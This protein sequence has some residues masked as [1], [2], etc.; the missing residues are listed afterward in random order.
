[1]D[2]Y[3]R[4]KILCA[5]KGYRPQSAEILETLGVSSGTITGWRKGSIPDFKTLQKIADYFGVTVGYLMGISDSPH[6]EDVVE[7]I[8]D[9]LLDCGA[10]VFSGA[11]DNGPERTVIY[12]RNVRIFNDH[13]YSQICSDISA[14][15][16]DAEI[17]IA[18]AWLKKNVGQ[19]ETPADESYTDDEKDLIRK[20]RQLN[21]DGKIILKSTLIT[22]LRRKE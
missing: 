10:D 22:E 4:Y 6:G 9:L 19:E 8:T 3:E 13:D 2:F 14:Q 17:T 20:Y 5:E 12:E 11:G 18:E 16:K 21:D 7:R 1:M 15:I